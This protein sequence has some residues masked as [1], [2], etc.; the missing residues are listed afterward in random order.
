MS[1][2]S[3]EGKR[4]VKRWLLD[5]SQAAEQFDGSES[6]EEKLFEPLSLFDD[7]VRAHDDD[8]MGSEREQKI[9][10]VSF[11]DHP[12]NMPLTVDGFLDVAAEFYDRLRKADTTQGNSDVW[13][14]LEN[15]G[16]I[17]KQSDQVF[18]KTDEGQIQESQSD[19]SISYEVR[20][21]PRLAMLITH[22]RND[23]VN[24]QSV[25]MDDLVITQGKVD[26]DM[27]REHPYNIVQIPRLDVEVAVCDQINE[28]TFVKK[29][30]VGLEFWDHLSK[31]QLKSRDDVAHVDRHND[32]QWWS[33]ISEFLSGNVDP[34]VKKINVNSWSA[35]KPKLDI[36]L[37]KQSLLAHR[38][39][40]G[41]WLSNSK[42]KDGGKIGSYIL[43]YGVYKDQLTVSA[44]E[45][46]LG[47]AGRGVLSKTS[48]AQLNQEISLENDLDYQHRLRPD[49]LCID[50]IKESLLVHR[51]KTGEWLSNSKKSEGGKQGSFVLLHGQYK[52]QLTV[53]TLEGTLVSARRGVRKKTSIAQLNQEISLENNLDYQNFMNQDDLCIDKI[54]NSLLAHRLK[55]GEWLLRSKEDENGVKGN[56]T[57]QYGDY[58]H[59]E[60]IGSIEN[61]LRNGGRGLEGGSSVA[62]LSAELSQENGLDYT[63]NMIKDDLD[64]DLIKESL[65]AHRLQTG[66]WLSQNKS[67]DD[68]VCGSYVLEY[69]HYAGQLKIGNLNRALHQGLLGLEGSTTIAKLNEE[70]SNEH[71]LD[72]INIQNQDDLDIELIKQGL[73]D[74][75][76]QTG[77]WLTKGNK[78]DDGKSYILE[79]GHYAGQI[80]IGGLDS[81]LNQGVR[82]LSGDSSIA[83]LNAE[84]KSE[85]E[86]IDQAEDDVQPS[87]E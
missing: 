60:K 84:L 36:E 13:A 63:N 71:T 51:L 5:A 14:M 23:G 48:I 26:T 85:L 77:K 82:G 29:G 30:T 58:A 12:I 3:K 81:A 22:L 87:F 31:D 20:T 72:Y 62:R 17:V 9:A 54:K 47:K 1:D 33:G 27:M 65:L 46:A 80:T 73:L 70:L 34:T 69:G 74:H 10:K 76:K 66:E 28:T 83:K 41:E 32:E 15:A 61:S 68:G 39:E 8:S 78:G 19:N 75:R 53:S 6:S 59:V 57:L 67:A 21:E 55:T 42:K 4:Q 43:Q 86:L 49:D 44:I 25:Y 52:G 50:K 45:T 11:P 7:F 35:R 37:I 56:F 16:A 79:Y 64:I 2:F 24:G 40:T 38:L 18:V